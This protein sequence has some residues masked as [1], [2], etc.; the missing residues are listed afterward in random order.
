MSQGSGDEM[1]QKLVS[2]SAISNSDDSTEIF[3][4]ENITPENITPAAVKKKLEGLV[5]Q[6][7]N[8]KKVKAEIQKVIKINNKNI[9]PHFDKSLILKD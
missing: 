4:D 9:M 1:S 5:S 8:L 2:K 7:N 6:L 3:D